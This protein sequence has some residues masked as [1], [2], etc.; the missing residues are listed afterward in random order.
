MLQEDN[1]HQI[2]LEERIKTANKILKNIL[3]ATK[4]VKI[5]TSKIKVKE[6]N[7]RQK[8]NVC[9]RNLHTIKDRWKANECY[10]NESVEKNLRSSI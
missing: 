1:N 2:D 9:I 10:L 4:N 7:N 8:G 5:K 6:H 3:Y